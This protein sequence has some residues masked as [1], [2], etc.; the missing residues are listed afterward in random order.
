MSS[1]TALND[2]PAETVIASLC[3]GD[4]DRQVIRQALFLRNEGQ[5]ELFALARSR[6]DEAF[7]TRQA[8]VRSV[9]ELSNICRQMCKYCSMARNSGIERYTIEK[10]PVLAMAEYLYGV[11]R[12]VLLLQSGENPA[13]KFIAFVEECVRDI[14]ARHPDFEII[15]CVG[16]LSRVQYQRL[17]DAGADRYVLKFEASNPALY[18]ALKS[19]DTLDKRLECL[20]A[21]IELGFKVGSGNMIGLP[22]QTVEDIVDDLFLVGREK[23]T[24]MS[25][26]VFIPGEACDFRNEVMGDV[27]VT[28]NF[29]ALMRI[30]YPNRLMPTTSALETVKTG[31][32]LRGL[33]AGANTITIHDG[34]PK[35]MADLFP[36]YTKKRITP[37]GDFVKDLLTK[38]N[39]TM[40]PGPLL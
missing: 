38:I 31:G 28:L 1:K 39:L 11:G 16:N 4:T 24:M 19:S 14:K 25:S 13:P 22:G 18:Q 8:E 7:P 3:A 34:T 20:H 9:I 12:R 26:T 37:N 23:L 35:E 36:I 10:E 27:E 6:R 5:D 30:L 32:I 17:R 2:L 21:L 29:M 40:A 33:E 15:L